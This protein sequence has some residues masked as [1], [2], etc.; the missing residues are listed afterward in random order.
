MT[1]HYYLTETDCIIRIRS[2]RKPSQNSR[3]VFS[4]TWVVEERFCA[5]GCADKKP[6]WHATWDITWG[7]LSQLTYIGK[8]NRA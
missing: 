8:V 5:C 7:R 2:K 1:Y 4:G 3:A 6:T